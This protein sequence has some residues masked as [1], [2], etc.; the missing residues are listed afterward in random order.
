MEQKLK[1][2]EEMHIMLQLE[3][4]KYKAVLAETVGNFVTPSSDAADCLS[5]V[6]PTVSKITKILVL[7]GDL[8]KATKECGRGREQMESKN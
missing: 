8:T 6:F 2:A 1:E 3:C 5:S 7:G 4:E